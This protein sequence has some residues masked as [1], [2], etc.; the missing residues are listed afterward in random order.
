MTRDMLLSYIND[1][2]EEYQ[3]KMDEAIG[4]LQGSAY[5]ITLCEFL[6]L[7]KQITGE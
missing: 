4:P 2:I 7:R 5:G 6:L 3:R 1:K